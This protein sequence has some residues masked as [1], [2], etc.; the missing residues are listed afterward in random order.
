MPGSL[1]DVSR[2]F[3]HRW[4]FF[5]DATAFQ[6]NSFPQTTVAQPTPFLC[7]AQNYTR[8]QYFWSLKFFI[9][10][11]S[12]DKW[13]LQR[14]PP[15][16]SRHPPPPFFYSYFP[17]N[18]NMRLN[19]TTHEI[20]WTKRTFEANKCR[21]DFSIPSYPPLT[22]IPTHFS[23]THDTET[24]ETRFIAAVRVSVLRIS[25][26]SASVSP[27]SVIHLEHFRFTLC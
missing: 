26:T 24:I 1:F 27:D 21:Q 23:C 19:V 11:L 14:R 7:N 10:S 17:Y 5:T 9:G 12:A 22:R 8:R 25:T 16:K 13:Y 20:S 18:N 4:I 6:I 3:W 2:N 15:E